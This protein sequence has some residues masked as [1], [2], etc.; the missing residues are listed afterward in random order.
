MALIRCKCRKSQKLFKYLTPAQ[1]PQGWEG[2]CC[3]EAQEPERKPEPQEAPK[4][5]PEPKPEP[6]PEKPAPKK[7]RGRKRKK[8]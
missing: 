5:A 3:L 1:M 7:R 8:Q 6:Q 2:E 4:P